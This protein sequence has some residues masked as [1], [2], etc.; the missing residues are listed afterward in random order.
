[1]SRDENTP[2]LEVQKR[3]QI[4]KQY[5]FERDNVDSFSQYRL[6]SNLSCLVISVCI[7]KEKKKT[8]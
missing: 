2:W 1:M 8:S 4:E 5:L 6:N 7:E 3:K